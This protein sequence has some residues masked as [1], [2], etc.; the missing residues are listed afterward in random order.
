MARRYHAIVWID[1]QEARIFQFDHAHVDKVVIHPDSS[2]HHS[3]YRSN[4]NSAGHAVEDPHFLHGVAMAV[5]GAEKILIVGPAN[6]K[7]ELAH[8]IRDHEPL[9][10][11]HV[12]GVET[13]DHPTDNA[14]VAL[15]RHHFRADH[16]ELPRAD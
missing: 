4:P 15:A 1:H 5:A 2:S 3:H 10:A 6:A 16:Q 13:V 9:L 7:T 8:H 14:L 12:A 11:P